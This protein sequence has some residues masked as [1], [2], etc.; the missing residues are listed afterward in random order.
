MFEELIAGF[1][2]GGGGGVGLEVAG[3]EFVGEVFACVEVFEEAG[4]CL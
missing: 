2:D 1:V 4:G 3:G